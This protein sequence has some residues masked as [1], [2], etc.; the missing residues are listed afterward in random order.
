MKVVVAVVDSIMGKYGGDRAK[1][2]VG[3]AEVSKRLGELLIHR[4]DEPN[5]NGLD[6]L[7]SNRLDEPIINIVDSV[8]S[9]R[10]DELVCNR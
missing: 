1:W 6:G 5:I 4:L 9:N 10:L 8:I 7:V 2:V 3:G